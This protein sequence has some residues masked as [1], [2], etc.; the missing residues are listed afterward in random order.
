MTAREIL[1]ELKPLGT[2]GYKKVLLNTR[3]DD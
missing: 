3:T 2:D 1:E